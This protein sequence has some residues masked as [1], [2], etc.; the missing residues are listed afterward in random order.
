MYYIKVWC[1]CC[2]D[3]EQGCFDGRVELRG[4]YKSFEEAN[5]AAKELLSGSPWQAEIV[6]VVE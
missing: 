5:A 6:E 1:P 2:E 3:D 4:P